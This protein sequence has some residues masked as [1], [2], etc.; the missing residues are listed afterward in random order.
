LVRLPAGLALKV[1][2]VVAPPVNNML[3]RVLKRASGGRRLVRC[4][5]RSDCYSCTVKTALTIS[6]THAAGVEVLRDTADVLVIEHRALVSYCCS[7]LASGRWAP[8][9]GAHHRAPLIHACPILS[10]DWRIRVDLGRRT[11]FGH[12]RILHI[13]LFRL[14]ADLLILRRIGSVDA[15]LDIKILPLL[16]YSEVIEYCGPVSEDFCRC[17]RENRSSREA[18]TSI[19][20]CITD[21]FA[22]RCRTRETSPVINMLTWKRGGAAA[23]VRIVLEC[24]RNTRRS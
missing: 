14:N 19:G 8:A 18:D 23:C 21:C 24:G 5:R 6:I 1:N 11:D 15:D 20:A 7:A 16:I 10:F 17:T 13:E 22:K 2:L 3:A 12:N 9:G 4:V